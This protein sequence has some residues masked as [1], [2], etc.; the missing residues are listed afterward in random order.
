MLEE[1]VSVLDV[2]GNPLPVYC[3]RSGQDMDAGKAYRDY[4]EGAMYAGWTCYY[5]FG[6]QHTGYPRK[7]N[8][9]V[10]DVSRIAALKVGGVTVPLQ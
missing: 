4:G 10:V 2:D 8:F 9:M 7:E 5:R 1:T 6:E 3:H